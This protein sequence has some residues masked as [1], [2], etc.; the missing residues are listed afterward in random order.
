MKRRFYSFMT[1][2]GRRFSRFHSEISF[3]VDF[4]SEYPM[5][6]DLPRRF[7]FFA[8]KFYCRV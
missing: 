4:I 7:K 5:S 6:E 2:L 8:L 3:Y 1:F